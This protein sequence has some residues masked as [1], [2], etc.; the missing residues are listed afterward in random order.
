MIRCS[1]PLQY[2]NTRY[3]SIMTSCN[4]QMIVEIIVAMLYRHRRAWM[5]TIDSVRPGA[6][7]LLHH[8]KNHVNLHP[9]FLWGNRINGCE[10]N[11]FRYVYL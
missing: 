11:Y 4:Y 2:C 9:P 7:S 10:V 8:Y 1:A 3:E 6:W 5:Q